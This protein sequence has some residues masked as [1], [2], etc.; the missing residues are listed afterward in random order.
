MTNVI[1]SDYAYTTMAGELSS[2]LGI[3]T[4]IA[5]PTIPASFFPSITPYS[6]LLG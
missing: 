3:T 1:C 4:S 5:I 6:T 2:G